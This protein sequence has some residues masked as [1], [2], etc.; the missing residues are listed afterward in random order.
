M[1]WLR[2]VPGGVE[3]HLKVVPGAS[4]SA[5]AGVL[6]D[7]LKLRIAAPPE[8]GR[9]NRAVEEL[10]NDL[11]GRVCMVTAGQGSPLKSV[12]VTG[13]SAEAVRLALTR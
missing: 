2:P 8:G 9:A 1:P 11:T 7:R 4:R 3:L 6:G 10:L 13:G 12:Q 5:V